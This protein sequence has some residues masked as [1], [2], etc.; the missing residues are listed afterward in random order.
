MSGG[1]V[2][3]HIRP[4]KS[5]DRYAFLEFL[6]KSSQVFPISQYSYVGFASH[7][8]EEYKALHTQFNVVDMLSLETD[9]NVFNRQLFN[10]PYSCITCKLLSSG[11]FIEEFSR[12]R[13]E[14]IPYMIWLDYTS[15]K[16]LKAQLDEISLLVKSCV[17]GDILKIT[18]NA[19]VTSLGDCPPP[20]ADFRFQKLVDRVGDAA[21]AKIEPLMIT[22]N[23]YPLALSFVLEYYIEKALEEKASELIF[24]PITIFSYADGQQM[25]TVTGVFFSSKSN[26]NYFL[27]KSGINKW[28]L[29]IKKWGNINNIDLPDLTLKERLFID[30]MLPHSTPKKI[31]SKL[32]FAYEER[33]SDNLQKIK[34]YKLYYRQSNHFSKIV[35]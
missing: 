32:K 26:R 3:Y 1:D 17:D 2:S 14:N 23:K 4:K 28:P 18:L 30:S 19:N 7:S 21:T 24:Q 27:K 13:D 31:A 12:S 29:F 16:K 20:K 33:E 6:S 10:K 35:I 8:F 11:D 15:P 5:I 22:T 9:P 34:M 25:L